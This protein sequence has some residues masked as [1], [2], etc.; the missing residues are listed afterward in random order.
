VNLGARRVGLT[1][2]WALL[3]AATLGACAS[4]KNTLASDTFDARR[5][6]TRELINRGDW[7]PAF[8]YVDGL[9]RERPRDVEVLILRGTIYRERALW[10]ESEVDLKEAVMIDDRSAEAH[11][12]LGILYDVTMRPT[13]AEP[14]HRA[15][16]KLAPEEATY[17]NNLGFSLFLR[18]KPRDAI[19]YYE[20]AA[21]LEPTSR[22]VRTN[23]GFACAATGD[24]RRAAHEF[25]MGGTPAEAKN[26]LGFAYERRGDLKQAFDLYREA[27]ELDPKSV[28]ARSNLVHAALALGR[29]LPA[30][31]SP[32]VQLSAPVSSST[33]PPSPAVEV[34]GPP[35]PPSPSNAVSSPSPKDGRP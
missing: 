27:T 25:E 12:A 35:A 19:T 29:E 17:L 28:H 23:L 9:H 13:L 5:K 34:V 2:A 26:N 22:R 7:G 24:L 6:L 14:Q 21:R 15:A 10:R 30:S 32:A 20:Q 33:P 18:G 16:V 11:A 4:Q 8:A 31:A 1:G 3:A